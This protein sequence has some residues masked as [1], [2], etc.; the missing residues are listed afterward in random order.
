MLEMMLVIVVLCLSGGI[1]VLA[2]S[3]PFIWWKCF[4]LEVRLSEAERELRKQIDTLDEALDHLLEQVG[5][6]PEK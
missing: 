6:K 5:V 3:V 1:A 2:S 4:Q